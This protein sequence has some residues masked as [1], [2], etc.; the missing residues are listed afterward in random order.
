ML[1][2]INSSCV[3]T[4]LKI[5]WHTGKHITEKPTTFN[6]SLVIDFLFPTPEILYVVR[7]RKLLYLFHILL[8]RHCFESIFRYRNS[9]VTKG[10]SLISH[11]PSKS[12]KPVFIC[13]LS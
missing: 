8:R 5:K 11:M 12:Y 10:Q 9:Q 6:L 7:S 2:T 1:I 3:I 13:I 4:E